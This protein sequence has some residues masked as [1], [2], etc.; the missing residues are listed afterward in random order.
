M[1]RSALRYIAAPLLGRIGAAVVHAARQALDDADAASLNEARAIGARDEAR[2]LA[3]MAMRDNVDC[4]EDLNSANNRILDLSAEIGA[5]R[6]ELDSA[7]A[8]DEAHMRARS[9]LADMRKERDELRRDNAGLVT[10]LVEKTARIRDLETQLDARADKVAQCAWCLGDAIPHAFADFDK[11]IPL[12]EI[13]FDSPH[14][15]IDDIRARVALRARC[16]PTR[17]TSPDPLAVVCTLGCGAAVGEECRSA[18]GHID[19]G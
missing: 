12:C 19:L 4:R 3:A 6:S 14:P 17:R 2:S 7:A 11:T 16:C 5:L 13:D 10:S 8:D 18:V 1:I 15:Y 9:G